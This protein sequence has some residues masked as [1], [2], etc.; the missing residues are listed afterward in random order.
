MNE[1][2]YLDW[3]SRFFGYK[4]AKVTLDHNAHAILDQLF[5]QMADEKYCLT[6]FFTPPNEKEINSYIKTKGGELVDQKTVYFKPTEKH[7]NFSH[8][9]V[10]YKEIEATKKLKELIL[11]AGE[12]SRF[13]VDKKFTNNEYEKLYLEWL[14]KSLNNSIAQKNFVIIK[15]NEI[16]GITTLGTKDSNADIGLVAVDEKYRGQSMGYDLIRYA[17]TIAYEMGFNNIQVVTQLQNTG[18]CRLYEKCKFS[19]KNI[20]NIYHLWQ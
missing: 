7:Y 1:I 19:I 10:E 12:F 16:K 6:Y 9:I 3:D 20:T 15:D 8:E 17:D 13:R 5:K 14:K 2:E 11:Q 18:A 4:I